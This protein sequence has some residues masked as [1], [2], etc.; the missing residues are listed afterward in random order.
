M[1]TALHAPT[2]AVGQA[3]D[4]AATP[5]SN[6]AP[7]LPRN[8][9]RLHD[10]YPGA[11]RA[12][13]WPAHGDPVSA[14]GLSDGDDAAPAGV[15]SGAVALGV[16][17]PIAH[18]IDCASLVFADKVADPSS[19]TLEIFDGR[20]WRPIP[21]GLRC[22]RQDAS[23]RL[24]FRFE[25]VATRA[26]RVRFAAGDLPPKVAEIEVDRYLP[27]GH[28]VWPERLVASNQLEDDILASGEEASFESLSLAAL[29][30]TPVRALLGLKDTPDEIGVAWDGTVLADDTLT[31]SIGEKRR[32]LRDVRD[33]ARRTLL[34]G[35][36]PGTLVEGRLDDLA[37]RQTAFV[38]PTDDKDSP[39]VLWVR[40]ELENL[41]AR[42]VRTCVEA[43]LA[44][45][46]APK[47]VAR[48]G[49]IVRGDAIVLASRPAGTAGAGPNRLRVEISL[50]PRGTAQADFIYPQ[51]SLGTGT[52]ASHGARSFDEA[53]VAFRR[54]WDDLLAPAATIETPEDR[55]NR[56]YKAVLAQIFINADG[57]V[58]Y[59]GAK[60]SVYERSL[61]GIEESYCMRALA[62]SGFG[63]DAQRYMSATYLTPR[64]L[65]K[66][67]QCVPRARHQQYRNGLQP[68]YAATVY[69]LTRDRSWIA[70]HAPLLKQCAEWTIAQ[71]RK[72][73]VLE[74][75][76]KPPHWG[77][78]PKWAYGGDIGEM[79]CYPLY[80]NFCCWRG[81]VDTAW[82]MEELG[83]EAAAR[84]Y[85][86]EARE[87]RAALDAVV[88]SLYRKDAR[89]P[90]L[91]L[92]LGTDRVDEGEFYQLFA[93]CL[94]DVKPWDPRGPQTRYVTDFLK[95]D[96]RAFCLLPR[97]RSYGADSGVEAS[98]DIGPGGL[99]GIY[100]MGYVTTMLHADA[101]PEF[102]LGFYG[103]LAFNLDHETF[104]GRETNLIYASDLHVRGSYSMPD[105]S[106]PLPCASAVALL[107]L[108]DM[109]VTEER[110]EHGNASGK[111][112]LL[113][114]APR[115]WF[116]D[117]QSIRLANM[118]TP[119]GPMSLDVISRA[120]A[121][122]IDA[123]ISPPRRN[124]FAGLKL[125]L[126]HP[127]GRPIVRATV[128]G[129]PWSQIDPAGNWILLP[130]SEG[131]WRVTAHFQ[132]GGVAVIAPAGLADW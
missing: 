34:D 109:L 100:G 108:R 25:P 13:A 125:R 91:P 28:K 95:A 117:G 52:P 53:L 8:I 84:R 37:V 49:Q 29:S 94:L 86:D 93:G 62:F 72:T 10:E 120:Q 66:V 76:R 71:R 74:D 56:L 85:A 47:A 78:L 35:W 65:S 111:L 127:D 58:M 67:D 4:E 87:Y 59:Y 33:T 103:Y 79:L 97:F 129:Q 11:D 30:M 43:D 92:R 69:R 9:A 112:L 132:A 41:S 31:F 32:R 57:N 22:E 99:D 123:T 128:N 131:P 16:Q 80:P 18:V 2:S 106:D 5:S 42:P 83:D 27:A 39:G 38:C 107:Y 60:P 115:D 118:P 63:P 40:V 102:L 104:V 61:F 90:W 75:G 17:W 121:G 98:H 51:G 3:S 119:Y 55:V 113:A 116:R 50:A 20:Q 82:L 68:H 73:M 101:V 105:I 126:R 48:D 21:R 23:R 89:P 64:F 81:L 26:L 44:G 6:V 19:V 7:P 110:C 54:Y 122:R 45:G 24:A 77:L 130:P 46:Q 1:V 14:D 96:N 15:S 36:R 88:E 114:G 124:A 12:L 70:A